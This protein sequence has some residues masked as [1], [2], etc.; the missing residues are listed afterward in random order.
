MPVLV[1]SGPVQLL[2]NSLLNLTDNAVQRWDPALILS[3]LLPAQIKELAEAKTLVP[4][5]FGAVGLPDFEEHG[6]LRPNTLL[7]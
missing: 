6:A 7:V 1:R 2:R 4:S 5:L 3:Q